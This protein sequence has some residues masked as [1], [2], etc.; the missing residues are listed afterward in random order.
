VCVE[1]IIDK[2]QNVLLYGKRGAGKTFLTRL[3]EIKIKQLDMFAFPIS[4]NMTGLLAYNFGEHEN[5]SAFPRAILIQICAEIWK[6]LFGKDYLEL[7]EALSETIQ[8]IGLLSKAESTLKRIYANLMISQQKARKEW[9]NT[10]GFSAGAKGE[11]KRGDIIEQSNSDIL[12]FEFLEFV[13]AI[14]KYVLPEFNKSRIIVL[15]DEANH[16]PFFNQHEILERYLELF[17]AKSIQFLFV[18]GFLS[19]ES[20]NELPMSFETRLELKGFSKVEHVVE[21]IDR[22][23][24]ENLRFSR[25]AIDVLFTYFEGHPRMT[26]EACQRAIYKVKERN[27]EEVSDE[28]MELACVLLKEESARYN[29]ELQS[30]R[31]NLKK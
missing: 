27:L 9:S 20:I 4:I 10:L 3:I 11:M 18:A 14:N 13:D 7:R 15:C 21:F 2:K 5:A 8:E 25:S 19:F 29:Q 22:I 26:L 17:S 16:L 30:E 28:A 23:D 31:N 6:Q 24:C 12:P 1:S